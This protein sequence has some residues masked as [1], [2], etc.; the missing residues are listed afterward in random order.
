MPKIN[1]K[2]ILGGI[3]LVIL[4]AFS[5]TLI[6]E[7]DAG[8]I[9]VIQAPITG[10]ITVYKEAGWVWQGGGK[11]THYNKSN[12]F[13]FL[14]D[15]DKKKDQYT[16]EEG[17]NSLPVIWNDG[18][19]ASFSGSVRWDMPQTDDE[20]VKVHSIYGT[21][22]SIE[23]Q[24]VKTNMEKSI[25]LTGPLM[26]SKESYAERRSDLISLIEDQANKGVYRTKVKEEE[27]I[28]ELTGER[29]TTKLVT[30]LTDTTGIALRQE[31]SSISEYG[32]RLY[33]VSIKNLHYDDKVR[34]QIRTQQESIMSVQTA[35]ANARKAEQDAITAQKEGEANAAKA[36]W[37]IEVTK[38][39]LVT[40]AEA[41][42]AV[43]EQEVLTAELNKQRD[44]LEGEGIAAK[45]RLVMQAD[46][47]LNE[48]LQAWVKAQQFWAEAFAKHQHSVVPQFMTGG[49]AQNGALNFM[50]IM[51]AKAAKDLAL[52]LSNK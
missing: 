20:I 41:K 2:Y 9:V 32:L 45:K 11:A 36:K 38:A 49:G 39:K 15:E 22:E 51:G 16:R 47:A 37:E 27:V 12:Q 5:P 19:Q 7:V 18:G 35:I 46:G 23:R 1:F 8:E 3:A 29:K 40:E 30:I 24:L 52:D 44:I 34:D 4:L 43:A 10:N 21:Q 42:K 17:D 48:K 33:N 6:E 26:S 28:D 25:F 14:S 31:R 13:W 50:E